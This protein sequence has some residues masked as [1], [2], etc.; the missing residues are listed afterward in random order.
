MKRC[1]LA[2]PI[3]MVVALP[4]RPSAGYGQSVAAFYGGKQIK[5]VL[6]TDPGGDWRSGA[7]G[8]SATPISSVAASPAIPT[9]IVQNMP[10]AAGAS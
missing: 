4:T 10:G 5:L 8:C 7:G 3:V 1:N 2:L 9:V 6:G